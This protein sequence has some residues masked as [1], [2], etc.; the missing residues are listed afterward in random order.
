MG[1][2][3]VYGRLDS[4]FFLRD[5]ANAHH[6]HVLKHRINKGRVLVCDTYAGSRSLTSK[7]GCVCYIDGRS[8]S[9]G[10]E[11]PDPS[12]LGK[13][14]S[15][16]CPCTLLACI[17]ITMCDAT[18]MCAAESVNT[19]AGRRRAADIVLHLHHQ[20]LPGPANAMSEPPCDIQGVCR[21]RSDKGYKFI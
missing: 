13:V 5:V 9:A 1:C 20:I 14:C 15:L 3:V 4:Q 19:A 2:G 10:K 12:F 8:S 6:T 16:R 7:A 17:A 11:A 21:H 18:R